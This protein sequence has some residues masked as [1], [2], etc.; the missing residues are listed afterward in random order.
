MKIRIPK[1]ILS[2]AGA[3]IIVLLFR[4]FG[5]MSCLMP[6]GGMEHSI[7]GGERILVNRWSYGLRTPFTNLLGYHRWHQRPVEREEIVVFNNPLS[8]ET[9]ALNRREVYISRCTGLPG[10]TIWINSGKNEEIHP[11]VVPRKGGFIAVTPWNRR[12]LRNALVMHEGRK[13][14]LRDN[15]L[16]VDDKPAQVCYFSQDYY[17]MSNGNNLHIADSRLFGFVPYSHIIGKACL[18]WFSKIPA[19]GWLEGYRWNRFFLPIH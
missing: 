7:L 16:Y 13:A 9:T 5:F 15:I 3:V 10:D 2:L 17:W 4:T 14:E 12:L 1:W 6:D 18:I 11:L 19:T 8:I